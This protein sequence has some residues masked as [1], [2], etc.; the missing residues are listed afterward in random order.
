M[1]V[2]AVFFDEDLDPLKEA[3]L[4]DIREVGA[5]PMAHRIE[6]KSLIGES[7]TVLSLNELRINQN[8]P[9]ELFTETALGPSEK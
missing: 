6:M 9:P 3:R 2:Q 8:L 7:K 4:T 1:T 5:V